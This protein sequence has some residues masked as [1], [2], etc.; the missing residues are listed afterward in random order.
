MKQKKYEKEYHLAKHS[1]LYGDEEY[2]KLRAKISFI[3]YLKSPLN[4]YSTKSVFEFGCG[5][6]QNIYL[7]KKNSVGYDTSKFALKFC[8]KKGIKVTNNLQEL[9][10]KKFDVVLCCEVLEHLENPLKALKQMYSKLEDEGKLI[11]LLPI[12]KW[13]RVNLKDK[14]QHLFCWN[15]QTITNLLLR[16][17]FIPIDYKI[18]RMTGFKK[19][20]LF[21]R[22]SF[23]L[24]LFLIKLLA[25]I[26][27]S[28]HMK[29]IAVKK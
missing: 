21:S 20:L 16:A 29:I 26:T 9:K 3:K 25:I 1:Y 15:Y 10:G 2:Y 11:L 7:T 14:N 5:L 23:K 8:K 17:R 13:K 28:K 19:F 12:E 22:I 4:S 27:G 6:G 24:Y 18:M